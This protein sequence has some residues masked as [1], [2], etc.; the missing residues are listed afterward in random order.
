MS[1]PAI[2]N[3]DLDMELTLNKI[4]TLNELE[5]DA[6]VA[7][8]ILELPVLG[9]WPCFNGEGHIGI[10]ADKSWIYSAY[11]L[12][13]PIYRNPD[14][15]GQDGL[16]RGENDNPPIYGVPAAWCEIV[17]YLSTDNN[18][19]I[20]AIEKIGGWW[21][22]TSHDDPRTPYLC[23]FHDHDVHVVAKTLALAI[24]R[25][26]LLTTIKKS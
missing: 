7:K 24:C 9:M 15:D 19:A 8:R 11:S 23:A 14:W 16:I 26:L 6:F 1:N 20:K 10:D 13:R 17:D 4:M 18:A 3:I 12:V 25:A 22:L 5:L 21:E 2:P